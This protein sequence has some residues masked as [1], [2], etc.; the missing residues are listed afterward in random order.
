MNR[1]NS[2]RLTSLCATL[3]SKDIERKRKKRRALSSGGDEKERP[4]YQTVVGNRF[5]VGTCECDACSARRRELRGIALNQEGN[6]AGVCWVDEAMDRDSFFYHHS[7]LVADDD[8]EDEDS[9]DVGTCDSLHRER[10]LALGKI[11]VEDEQK[12]GV[13]L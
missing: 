2:N 5:E 1:R 9:L 13:L 10:I 6:R 3:T 12:V 8:S 7:G 4:F 11:F